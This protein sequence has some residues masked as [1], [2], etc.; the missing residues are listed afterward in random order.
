[1]RQIYP[2]SI[3]IERRG[4]P[5]GY[6]FGAHIFH[7]SHKDERLIINGVKQ[8]FNFAET[9]VIPAVAGSYITIY[10]SDSED[11]VVKAFVK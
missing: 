9:F 8:R 2:L 10:V 4:W 7:Y 3:S 11:M 1:M 5:D 6:K